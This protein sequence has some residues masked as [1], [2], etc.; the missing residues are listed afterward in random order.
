[1]KKASIQVSAGFLVMMILALVA[2]GLGVTFLYNIMGQVEEATGSINEQTKDQIQNILLEPGMKVAFPKKNI[3]INRGEEKIL[4]FGVK[5]TLSDYNKFKI[6]TECLKAYD[7][8]DNELCNDDDPSNACNECDDWVINT[9]TERVIEVPKR[10]R[11]VDN[12]FLKVPS[13]ADFGKYVFNLEVK[14]YKNTNTHGVYDT[15]KRFYLTVS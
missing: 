13:E 11:E 9:Q 4:G 6:E 7:S 15:K 12:L 10:E 2:F 3:E 5:N 8:E 1:M 14:K